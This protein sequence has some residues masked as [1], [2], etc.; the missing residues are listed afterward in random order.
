MRPKS[1]K[2][3]L[4]MAEPLEASIA[5][6][7]LR[8]ANLQTQ[9][10]DLRLALT[11]WR[12]TREYTKPTQERLLQITMQCARLVESWQEME[13]R[14][15]GGPAVLEECHADC[16][17]FD[18]RTSQRIHAL[19]R[20][21][22]QEWEALPR[23]Q[24]DSN[25]RLSEQAA[26]LAESCVTAASLALRG[27]ASAESRLVALERDIQTGMAQLSHDL[28]LV[29]TELRTSRQSLAGANS[30]FPLESVMRSH[31]ELRDSDATPP[32]S[33]P[34]LEADAPRALPSPP[35]SATAPAARVDSLERA[36]ESAGDAAVPARYTWWQPW[37]VVI[38]LVIALAGAAVFGVWLQRRIDARLNEAALL[39]SAAKRERDTT[40][41]TAREEAAR[42]VAEA[43]QTAA[44]AQ[45]VGNV[46]A[47]PDLVR[48][49]LTGP[50]TDSRA[51]AQVLF[52][53]SRGMVFSASRLE[54]AGAGKTYQLWLLT[55]DGPVSAGLMTPDSAGR[56]TLVADVP[57]TV[58]GRLTGAMVT[59]EP[60]GGGSEPSGEQALV[61]VE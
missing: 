38:V 14:R 6:P 29:L 42:Q 57:L 43:R 51:F 16:R 10:D 33:N 15:N 12:R 5:K 32:D 37:Y 9:I 18:S 36:I 50:G 22:E 49:W 48:Y 1:M 34:K 61:R 25:R 28:Q 27:F 13:R 53:R 19:E 24:D 3:A 23:D 45:I 2:K 55:R 54:P 8:T 26:S 4:I 47:A 35:E 40:I 7:D 59:M 60:A 30:S 21:I 41:A 56:V 31:P 11:D 39:V 46:L 17:P 20:A 58:S 52:S 44:Q